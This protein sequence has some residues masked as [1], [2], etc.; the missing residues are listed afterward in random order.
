MFLKDSASQVSLLAQATNDW[1]PTIVAVVVL[2]VLAVVTVVALIK[3][4]MSD[5]LMLMGVVGT[6]L[7]ATIGMIGSYFF[8]ND[9]IAE[10]SADASTKQQRIVQLTTDLE[11]ANNETRAQE[12]LVAKY[13]SE[14]QGLEASRAEDMYRLAALSLAVDPDY[15]RSAIIGDWGNTITAELYSEILF[16]TATA[17]QL[18]GRLD[19]AERQYRKIISESS[20]LPDDVTAMA[21]N[22]L[23]M[24]LL[25]T[26]R[27]DE[28]SSL[29]EEVRR[30]DDM[31]RPEVWHTISAIK[32]K[33]GNLAAAIEAVNR[34]I[35]LAPDN[36]EYRL[37]YA[38]ILQEMGRLEEA[39]E[40][41]IDAL[42]MIENL[43]DIAESTV[44]K[45]EELQLLMRD[46][47]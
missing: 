9:R 38:R 39:R 30:L 1:P 3:H 4:K 42:S 43:D 32:Y 24:I 6:L 44:R 28:A 10:L 5:V 37:D 17:Y 21:I 41:L 7:G 45:L 22:N 31:A 18:Q 19:E 15:T 8:A 25:E 13:L 20:E 23:A 11:T 40:Q 34:A 26:G 16:Q 12:V 2:T 47:P 46:S 27:L 14:V 33:E 29:I 35:Q 36:V